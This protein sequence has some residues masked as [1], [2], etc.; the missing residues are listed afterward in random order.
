MKSQSTQF[1]SP[2]DLAVSIDGTRAYWHR[3]TR[4]DGMAVIRLMRDPVAA[5]DSD[6]NMSVTY[7]EI[8]I[9]IPAGGIATLPADFDVLWAENAPVGEP[10]EN[11]V[12]GR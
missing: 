7:D 2:P 5:T 11:P 9:Q 8:E 12:R 4:E 10:V 1:P 3:M 6:G